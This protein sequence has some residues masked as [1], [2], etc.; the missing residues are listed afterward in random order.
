M[1]DHDELNDHRGEAPLDL[2][3]LDEAAP[4][5]VVCRPVVTCTATRSGSSSAMR[6]RWHW[7]DSRWSAH[8]PV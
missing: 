6:L 3:D 1:T 8:P 2:E 7:D 4:R 5:R